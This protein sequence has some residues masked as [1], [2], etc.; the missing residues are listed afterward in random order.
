VHNVGQWP[1]LR[2]SLLLPAYILIFSLN[3]RA[4]DHVKQRTTINRHIYLCIC[5]SSFCSL[6]FCT[7]LWNLVVLCCYW[8]N[9]LTYNYL[10]NGTLTVS[11]CAIL[12]LVRP[13]DA[14]YNSI[15]VTQARSQRQGQARTQLNVKVG[16]RLNSSECGASPPVNNWNHVVANVSFVY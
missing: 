7:V 15:N 10:H 13:F 1:N 11:N 5:S 12:L 9:K 16:V 8:N 2:Q 4:R 6:V 3:C 14:A